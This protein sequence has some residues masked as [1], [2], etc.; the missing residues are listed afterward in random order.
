MLCV[1]VVPVVSRLSLPIPMPL[2]RLFPVPFPVAFKVPRLRS[3]WQAPNKR[4]TLRAGPLPERGHPARG[5]SADWKPAPLLGGAT[6]SRATAQ[7][8]RKGSASG[9]RKE[10]KGGDAKGA[11]AGGREGGFD[12]GGAGGSPAEMIGNKCAFKEAVHLIPLFPALLG[13]PTKQKSPN[14]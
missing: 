13:V 5:L 12:K 6:S 7:G 3:V 14:H 1:L 11:K 10:R 4:S 9:K 2:F 8:I